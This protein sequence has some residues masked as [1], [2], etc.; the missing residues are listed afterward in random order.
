M[1][2]FE[3]ASVEGDVIDFEITANR[4]DCLSLAGFAREVATRYGTR[5]TCPGASISARR[6]WRS[7][8]LTSPSRIL[9]AARV[10]APRSPTSPS[11]RRRT[12]WPP[13]LTAAGVRSISNVVD[14]TNYVL[15]ELGQPMHAFDLAKLAGPELRV[16]TASP[17]ET[18]QTLDGQTRELDPE[19]LVIADK[20]RAQAIGG[21]MGG[22]DSEV[23]AT[24][25]TIALESAWFL[26][27]SVRRTSKKLGLSTE[28]SYRFERGADIDAAA[29][30]AGARVRAARA[31]RRRA[32][33]AAGSTRVPSRRRRRLAAF[34]VALGRA[35]CSA[36]TVAD[37][38]HHPHP[39][40]SWLRRHARHPTRAGTSRSRRGASMSPAT[41]I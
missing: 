20:E 28:A 10:T 36:L 21:V 31:D 40:R 15:L 16:R 33:R 6:P 11:A 2:G 29:A 13:R 22:A 30:G 24:T 37:R 34:D 23:S 8:P 41:W 27:S 14:V 19:M 9:S 39:D 26:P 5:C 1:T 32:S 38:R 25:T 7:D 35:V 4:P 17:G 3:V 18:I 12:G